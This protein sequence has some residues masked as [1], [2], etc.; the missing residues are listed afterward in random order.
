[1]Q[2]LLALPENL[3]VYLLASVLLVPLLK[4]LGFATPPGYLMA[5]ILVGPWGLALVRDAEHIT[6]LM[7][8]SALAFIFFLGLNLSPTHIYHSLRDIFAYS[9]TQLLLTSVVFTVITLMV[10]RP[11]YEAL[12]TGLALSV[13][14]ATIVNPLCSERQWRDT[15]NGRVGMAVV[16]GHALALIVLLIVIPLLGFGSPLK[17]P[18][19]LVSVIKALTLF[20]VLVVLGRYALRFIYRYL[21]ASDLPEIFIAF[22]LLVILGVGLLMQSLDLSVALGCLVCGLLLA[23]SEYVQEIR[24]DFAPFKGLLIGLFFVAVGMRVDFGLLLQRPSEALGLILVLLL[25]KAAAYYLVAAKARLP[26]L[27]R[28]QFSVLL[29]QSGELSLLLLALAAAEHAVSDKL[30]AM[31]TIVVAVSMLLTPLLMVGVRRWLQRSGADLA[32]GGVVGHHRANPDAV[33]NPPDTPR[34]VIAGF[35]R[36]GQVVSRMLRASNVPI[37]I[38]DNDPMHVDVARSTGYRIHYGDALRPALMQSAGILNAPV[39]VIALQDRS[40]A[41]ALLDLAKKKFPHLQVAAIAQDMPHLWQMQKAGAESVQREIFDSAILMGED[42]LSMLGQ[43][44]EEVERQSEAFRDNDTRIVGSMYG[45]WSS[46][47][48]Q[49]LSRGGSEELRELLTEDQ[50][51]TDIEKRLVADKD[52]YG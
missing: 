14:A 28:P 32:N 43:D 6:Q 5:G 15:D 26:L 22:T 23:D 27:E 24:A 17:E 16:Q 37:S 47:K 36:A 12:A 48:S 40:R 42:V 21:A 50:K 4:R 18:D 31:L 9:G 1:M 10:G 49:T 35:G 30:S 3:L 25:V 7:D 41:L 11:L 51:Q 45:N 44:F 46:G 39:L 19:G 8:F 29:C 34:V 20:V 52:R 2:P 38:I 33:R 13:S